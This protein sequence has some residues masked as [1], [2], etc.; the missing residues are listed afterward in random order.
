MISIDDLEGILDVE[1]KQG[2]ARLEGESDEEL[3][4]RMERDQKEND[5]DS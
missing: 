1:V 2:P 5:S 4:A 3:I